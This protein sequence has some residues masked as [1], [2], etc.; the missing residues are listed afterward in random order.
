MELTNIEQTQTIEAAEASPAKPRTGGPRSEAGKARSALNAIRH[1]LTGRFCLLPNED[2]NFYRTYCKEYFDFWKPANV[3]E[4]DLV[5]EIVDNQWR[6]NRAK[7][8]EQGMLGWGHFGPAGEFEADSPET[9]A[10]FTEAAHF[11]ENHKQF[12]NL[13]LYEQRI[14]RARDHAMR[15]LQQMQKI[16]KAEEQVQFS[17]AIKLQKL[18]KML[19]IPFQPA[20]HQFVF[21]N[22]EIEREARRRDLL[23]D[24]RIAEKL[25]YDRDRFLSCRKKTSPKPNEEAVA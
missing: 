12:A 14:Q 7:G 5:Q 19:R 9:H 6:L 25:D 17:E 24:V 1:G 8:Y 18:H 21:S 13:A 2:I 22:A 10:G 23:D 20:E 3:V 15:S 4:R 11:F 16:R